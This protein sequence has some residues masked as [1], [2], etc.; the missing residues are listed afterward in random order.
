[1]RILLSSALVFATALAGAQPTSPDAKEAPV[2][3]ATAADPHPHTN[4]LVHETSPYLVQHAHNPVDWYPWGD[5]AIERARTEGKPIFLSIGYSTCYWCH[6]MERESFED[7]AT[8]AL[9]NEHFVC[10]KVDREERPD[11]DDIYMA[12]V[13]MM[14]GRG[15]WPMS[16]FIDADTL[17]PFYAGTYFPKESRSGLPAFTELLTAIAEAWDTQRDA[18]RQQAAATAERLQQRLAMPVPPSDLSADTV[19]S[20][21]NGLLSIYDGVEG[22]FGRA[23]KFPQ[24]V[25]LELLLTAARDHGPASQAVRFTLDRMA[26]G[27][28]YDQVGGGFHRYSTDG[29]WRVPHFEKMLYDNGQLAS[30]YAESYANG[31]D[32]YDAQIVRET[33]DYILREMTAADG[34]FFSAQDAE[35]NAREG[36]NYLWTAGEI[37]EALTAAGLADDVDFTLTLYGLDRGTNFTDPHH[38]EDGPK[39]VLYL[40]ERPDVAAATMG[41]TPDVLAARRKKVNAALRAVRDR[42]QQPGTDDKIIAGWNGLMIAGM[43]DGGRVLGETKYVDAATRAARFILDHMQTPDGGLYRTARD[44]RAKIDAFL[45]DYAFV[46]HGLLALH[47]ASNDSTML[48]AAVRLAATAR[49]RFWDDFAGGYFDTL[50]DRPD[51]LV[52]AKSMSDGAVPCGNSVMVHNLIDLAERT[53][54]RAYLE[55]AART[56]AGMSHALA[57]RGANSALAVAGL[58]RLL[59]ADASVLGIVTA[60]ATIP[61]N[62]VAFAPSV[63]RVSIDV[64]APG[65][66][67]LEIHIADGLHLNAHEAGIENVIPFRIDLV[68]GEGYALDI[69]YPEGEAFGAEGLRVYRGTVRVPV[70]VRFAGVVSGQPRLVAVYQVCTD[71]VCLA[72]MQYRIPVRLELAS[73]P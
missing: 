64:E 13:Q 54:D 65:A 56:L 19:T 49:E 53:G 43:A 37:R 5:E 25:F 40:P 69:D 8:A 51:V 16:V 4:R 47:R 59:A 42:R 72:P 58:H 32:D 20:S 15:G 68:G 61:P 12:A 29:K 66:F 21:V 38:P 23:P 46:I 27:G 73:T 48:D 55:Q 62:P 18:I 17:A 28:M 35:V 11:L 30:V 70:K 22:G 31:G 39:N 41:L 9:M 36:L 45:E 3:P 67:E 71:T 52:R 7:E 50:A 6:V 60:G 14:T 34:A 2:P 10:I 26:M 24:P 57:T 33:L 1:M 63:N 44:G